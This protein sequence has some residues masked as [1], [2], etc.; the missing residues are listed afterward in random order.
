MK[1]KE[2]TLLK[3][4]AFFYFGVTFVLLSIIFI[5]IYYFQ[6]DMQKNLALER[7][8]NFSFQIAS[9]II[10]AQM[11]NKMPNCKAIQKRQY[12]FMLLD[13]KGKKIRGDTI[14]KKGLIIVDKSPLGHMGVWA[15]VVE[16]TTFEKVKQKLF[17][18]TFFAFILSYL[19]IA[20]L[21][22]YLILLLLKPIKEARE[23]ID[24]F[25]KDTTHELNT[26]ITALLMC[27]NEKS[28]QKKHNLER[29]RLSAKRVS[30]LY[31]DLIYIFLEEKNKKIIE[32]IMKEEILEQLQY[33]ELLAAKKKITITTSL[34]DSKTKMDKEDFKRLISNLLSNTIKY[35]KRGG[36]VFITLKKRKLI[37]EDTGIGI[38][39]EEQ[40]KIFEKYHRATD[41]EGGFGIGLSIVKQICN[42]YGIKITMHSKLHKGTKFTLEFP[43]Y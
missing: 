32:I 18:K 15:I 16:D 23:R 12:K 43:P 21:G 19:V 9:N 8:K 33:F 17:Y 10:Q 34:D 37:I 1:Y 39:K 42:E 36:Q 38:K 27:A 28:L 6:L 20:F 13:K 2:H 31:K 14:N 29:I 11:Q 22:Y 24:N 5:L 3:K 41:V 40:E 30:E 7:M 25:I 4:F 35:N 26:P